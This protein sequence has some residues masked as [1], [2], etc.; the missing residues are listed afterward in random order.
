MTR[1]EALLNDLSAKGLRNTETPP[2]RLYE[3]DW[4]RVSF[5]HRSV[6][7]FRLKGMI[8]SVAIHD[9]RHPLTGYGIDLRGESEIAAWEIASGGCGRHWLMW[10]D[11]TVTLVTV[12]V[13]HPRTS[14]AAARPGWRERNL[15]RADFE[16]VLRLDLEAVRAGLSR[17][18]EAW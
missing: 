7:L 16:R 10:L 14:W 11:R 12:A 15:Y 18:D 1:R 5:R 17:R 3:D 6:K 8:E 9:A 13:F 2:D 4:F